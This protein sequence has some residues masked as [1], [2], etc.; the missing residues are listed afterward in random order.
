MQAHDDIPTTNVQ[1][2]PPPT[3]ARPRFDPEAVLAQMYAKAA[4]VKEASAKYE[5]ASVVTQAVLDF[6]IRL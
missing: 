4:A 1:T 6:E 5:A 3:S 2:L